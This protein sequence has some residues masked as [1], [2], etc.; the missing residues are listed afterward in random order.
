MRHGFALCELEAS[1]AVVLSVFPEA[2]LAMLCFT[3]AHR[4]LLYGRRNSCLGT[5]MGTLA[6]ADVPS[7]D[8]TSKGSFL[9]LYLFS[10]HM[11]H[12]NDHIGHP[13]R[14]EHFAGNGIPCRGEHL[15]LCYGCTA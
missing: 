10:N 5:R 14:R 6:S 12:H 2:W 11:V 15:L 8:L 3:F 9:A 4:Y 1:A 13:K 7:P